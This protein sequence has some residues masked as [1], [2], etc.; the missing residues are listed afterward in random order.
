LTLAHRSFIGV[1]EAPAALVSTPDASRVFVADDKRI[2]CI[3][4]KSDAVS[5]FAAIARADAMHLAGG[6]LYAMRY[7][8]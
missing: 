7:R 6:Q 5:V 1:F 3:D 4:V 8:R 2:S